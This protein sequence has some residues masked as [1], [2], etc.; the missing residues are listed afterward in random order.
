MLRVIKK[1]VKIPVYVMIR[2]R[3]GDFMYSPI[4]FDVMKEDLCMLK[5]AGA[6]GFVFG[7][8]NQ[9]VNLKYRKT[10]NQIKFLIFSLYF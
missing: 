4:E 1:T 5:E 3:G 10:I 2:P 6:D 9:L 7:L 8:L